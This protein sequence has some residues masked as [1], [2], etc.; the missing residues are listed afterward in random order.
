[1]GGPSS[2]VESNGVPPGRI[3]DLG[4]A[5]NGRFELVMIGGHGVDDTADAGVYV[6]D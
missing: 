4:R 2:A 3:E 6:I 5:D 1:M